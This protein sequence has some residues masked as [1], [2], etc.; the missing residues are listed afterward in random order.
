MQSVDS[1]AILLIHLPRLIH[2]LER[3]RVWMHRISSV[4]I[5]GLHRDIVSVSL[6]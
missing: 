2:R 3:P 6:L 5:L 1:N 4:I